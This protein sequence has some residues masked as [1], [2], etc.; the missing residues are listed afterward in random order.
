MPEDRLRRLH[1][2]GQSIWL[3]LLSRELVE[4]GELRRLIDED[5][6]TGV[7]SNPSIFEK[8]IS[9]SGAYDDQIRRCLAETDDPRVVF[10]SERMIHKL[11]VVREARSA[12]APAED[13]SY[14]EFVRHDL[15][16]ELE[17]TLFPQG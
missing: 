6:V 11:Y 4:T 15:L 5:S 14:L 10:A 17:K 2:A 13:S 8:A 7:T 9:H 1:D 3:D 12:D 16:P